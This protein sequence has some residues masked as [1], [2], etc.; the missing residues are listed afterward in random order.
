MIVRVG[1][2]IGIASPRPTPATAVLTPTTSP[3]PLTS[4]PPEL[5]G[6]SAASVWIRLSISRP[7]FRP[8][9][10][11]VRPSAETTPAVTDPSKP[12]GFPIA[13]TSWPT[14]SV[15]ASP[16]TAGARLSAS[17]RRT[18]RS[19][20][21]SRPMIPN[22]YSRPSV[23]DARPAVERSATTCAEVSRKPSAVSTTALPAP[24]VAWPPRTRR[25]TRRLATDGASL[26][27][28]EMTM[29]EYASSAAASCWARS[30]TPPPPGLR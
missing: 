18:A 12:C 17:A 6:L 8:P 20:N 13:T 21:G 14:R 30:I 26:S 29:R 2:L 5:P 25:M 7:L 9:A 10:A 27:A 19:D 15:S 1:A 4:A 11:S 28:T 23:N 22:R 24:V 3:R 16:S